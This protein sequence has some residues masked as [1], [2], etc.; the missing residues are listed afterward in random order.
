MF[1]SCVSGVVD[2]G[3]RMQA[4]EVQRPGVRNVGRHAAVSVRCVG[5]GIVGY[6]GMQV[7]HFSD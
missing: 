7:I 1:A 2:T 3:G 5:F 6:W 4:R